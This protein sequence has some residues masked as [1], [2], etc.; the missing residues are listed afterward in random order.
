[1]SDQKLC[2]DFQA[3]VIKGLYEVTDL[4]RQCIAAPMVAYTQGEMDVLVSSLERKAGTK[5]FDKPPVLPAGKI[6]V[7]F[8]ELAGKGAELEIRDIGAD[9]C[10]NALIDFGRKGATPEE[11]NAY[12]HYAFTMIDARSWVTF[13]HINS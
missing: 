2:N 9:E 6:A 5:I 1:M 3:S 10:G 11:G 4:Q 7:L 13:K 12:Q 8:G